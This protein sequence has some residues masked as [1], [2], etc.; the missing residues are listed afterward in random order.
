[1]RAINELSGYL[2]TI[3]E[4]GGV[5]HTA[6]L[7]GEAAGL[8]TGFTLFALRKFRPTQEVHATGRNH[9]V[10]RMVNK[11]THLCSIRNAD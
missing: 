2:G 8:V 3:P 6:H 4:L 1:M 7:G 5:A 11:P 9:K 10:A